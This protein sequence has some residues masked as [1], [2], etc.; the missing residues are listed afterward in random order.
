M[1]FLSTSGHGTVGGAAAAVL[2]AYNGGDTV[3]FY[4]SSLIT[5]T[6]QHVSTRHYTNLTAAGLEISYS[7]VYG[8]VRIPFLSEAKYARY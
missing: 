5:Q 6:P 3:N 1:D 8:G 2:K 7:R 4:V